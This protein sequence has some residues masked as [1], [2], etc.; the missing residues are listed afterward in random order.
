M[1]G[2][3]VGIALIALTAFIIIMLTKDSS[4]IIVPQEGTSEG[5]S[6]QI[7]DTVVVKNGY[8]AFKTEE[9]FLKDGEASLKELSK[10]EKMDVRTEI[11]PGA[12]NSI[13]GSMAMWDPL[14]KEYYN[15]TVAELFT[16]NRFIA[17]RVEPTKN[18]LGLVY[19][20]ATYG[21]KIICM[22][23]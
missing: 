8:Y 9:V 6:S 12:L 17:F 13:I 16:T 10:G 19:V 7:T 1:S 22:P 5:T 3:V 4:E 15:D 20:A 23:L 18:E 14:P 11:S 2:I 21:N